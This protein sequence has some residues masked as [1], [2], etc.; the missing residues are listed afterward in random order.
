MMILVW[1]VALFL[2]WWSTPTHAQRCINIQPADREPA[3]VPAN[4]LYRDNWRA[5]E[6]YTSFCPVHSPDGPTV[7]TVLTVLTVRIDRWENDHMDAAVAPIPKGGIPDTLVLD[8]DE[9]ILGVLG[10]P[11]DEGYPGHVAMEFSDWRNG[12]PWRI[13][14]HHFNAAADDH[15]RSLDR[16]RRPPRNLP[17]A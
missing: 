4:I 3:A 14:V 13:D 2:P 12:L 11:I 17:H 16:D 10:T 15:V 9:R 5:W 7:L 6:F 8:P 1:F